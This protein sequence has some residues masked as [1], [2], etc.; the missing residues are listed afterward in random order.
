MNDINMLLPLPVTDTRGSL[1]NPGWRIDEP[2]VGSVVLVN[3]LTGTAYQRN[4]NGDWCSWTGGLLNWSSVL[5]YR[6]VF[7]VYSAPARATT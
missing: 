1:A 4:S 2:E 6:N 7:L 5:N 3:G